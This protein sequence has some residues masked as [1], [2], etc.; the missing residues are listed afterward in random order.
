MDRHS[1]YFLIGLPAS[2]SAGCGGTHRSMESH[3]QALALETVGEGSNVS[4]EAGWW[5]G[6]ED[7]F[8]FFQA[9]LHDAAFR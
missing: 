9:T 5:F 4:R 1:A 2:A 8:R 7:G 6:E 3:G